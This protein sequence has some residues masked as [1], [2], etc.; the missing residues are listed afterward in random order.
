VDELTLYVYYK[1]G[2]ETS[3][4]CTKMPEKA[5][6]YQTGGYCLKTW[7][8]EGDA[9][10]FSLQQACE[11]AMAAVVPEPENFSC[12]LPGISAALQ[13]GRRRNAY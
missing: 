3:H 7:T 9:R 2:V 13:G 12:R 6:Q 1:N 4:A 11:G 10:S 8:T 5:M